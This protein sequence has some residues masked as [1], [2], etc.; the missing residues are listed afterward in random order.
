MRVQAA[1]IGKPH[2]IRGEV[3]VQLL[4]DDPETR[5]ARGEVLILE[6]AS[7]LAPSGTLTV[8]GARWNKSI[9]VLRFEEVSDRNGAETLRNHHLLIDTEEAEETEG[10]YEHELTGL[11]VYAV[12]PEEWARAGEDP[13]RARLGEPVGT[14]TG[15]QTLPTQDLLAVT[16]AD[17]SES[18]VPF[19][20]EIVP[21]VDLEAGRI[22]ITPPPGLLEL[23]REDADASRLAAEDG[24]QD[25]DAQ[26]GGAQAGGA[27]D[28]EPRP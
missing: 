26:A 21:E 22:V 23:N 16:L 24:A 20:A 7:P 6:P 17:G 14:V 5:F 11:A 27:Q 8:A 25:G 10:Y 2:G 1:R 3:T 13:A 18:L 4:T 28:G 15:L 19:V 12:D 9:L